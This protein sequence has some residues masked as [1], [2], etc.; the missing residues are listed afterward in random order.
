MDDENGSQKQLLCDVKV[1]FQNTGL[2]RKFCVVER[3]AI[4]YTAYTHTIEFITLAAASTVLSVK[5][6]SSVCLSV[7][8]SRLFSNV[9]TIETSATRV[10]RKYC[11]RKNAAHSQ[12][13]F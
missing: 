8:L 13:T 10:L 11:G 4:F 6:R 7:C 9:K 1:S 2:L 3:Q 5:H 12:R